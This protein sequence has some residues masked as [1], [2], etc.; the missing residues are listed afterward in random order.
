MRHPD[1][2]TE[3]QQLYV[4]IHD[5][6]WSG[7]RLLRTRVELVDAFIP[8]EAHI[9]LSCRS[10][11]ASSRGITWDECRV[12]STTGKEACSPL[13]RR[14]RC[15]SKYGRCQ[16][17][18]QDGLCAL[19]RCMWAHWRRGGCRW[20]GQRP[21]NG[22]RTCDGLVGLGAS[23]VLLNRWPFDSTSCAQVCGD[24]H[25]HALHLPPTA[26]FTPSVKPCID[27]TKPPR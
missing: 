23:K 13:F 16:H 3:R 12:R 14:R 27:F 22:A 19:P 18:T 7:H 20:A 4:C 6:S 21:H 24:G 2:S 1:G 15:A 17:T 10:C 9:A 26:I 11:A 5:S 8:T 25:H